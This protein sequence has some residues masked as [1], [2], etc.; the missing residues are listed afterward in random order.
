[1]LIRTCKTALKYRL[2]DPVLRAKLVTGGQIRGSKQPILLTKLP[3][4]WYLYKVRQATNDCF[5][6]LNPTD[7][8]HF[9]PVPHFMLIALRNRVSRSFSVLLVPPVHIHVHL[10]HHHHHSHFPPPSLILSLVGL[11]EAA[12]CFE[13]IQVILAMFG[14]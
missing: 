7:I 3:D 1:M 5:L 6:P 11:R 14:T 10:H 9:R 2:P 4:T 8:P 12:D 13:Q